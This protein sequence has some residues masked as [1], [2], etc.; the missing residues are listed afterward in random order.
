MSG[1][2]DRGTV[3]PR[4]IQPRMTQRSARETEMNHTTEREGP[5]G[6]NHNETVL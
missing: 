1:A 2:A 3:E 5:L 6:T 4:E